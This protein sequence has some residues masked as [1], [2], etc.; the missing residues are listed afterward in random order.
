MLGE[1]RETRILKQRSIWEL[2]QDAQNM[3]GQSRKPR[4]GATTKT[5]TTDTDPDAIVVL[6][7]K[8]KR[9]N[10]GKR[11]ATW[12]T[13]QKRQEGKEETRT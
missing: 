8:R 11:R 10:K 7:N 3:G 13:A 1:E 9:D 2:G 12:I 5:S 4:D 6:K